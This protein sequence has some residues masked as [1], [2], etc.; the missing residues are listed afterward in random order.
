MEE[1]PC[2]EEP[3]VRDR[4]EWVTRTSNYSG[5]LAGIRIVPGRT[6]LDQRMYSK[7]TDFQRLAALIELDRVWSEFE[8][9][10]ARGWGRIESGQPVYLDASCNGYQHVASLLGDV[11]LADSRTSSTREGAHWICTRRWLR[12]RIGR[13]G[14]D[15][16]VPRG[17]R[18]KSPDRGVPREDLH[19]EPGKATHDRQGLWQQ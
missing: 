16:R 14:R 19:K 3:E 17:D 7:R 9:G 11:R 4:D 13:K 18:V 5:R 12:R 2:Q 10:E 15:S 6:G 8:R 1:W